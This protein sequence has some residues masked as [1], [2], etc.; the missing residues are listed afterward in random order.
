MV[1]LYCSGWPTILAKLT[2]AIEAAN[3]QTPEEARMQAARDA[4]FGIDSVSSLNDFEVSSFLGW[5]S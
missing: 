5:M 4:L 2:T 1:R 3:Q